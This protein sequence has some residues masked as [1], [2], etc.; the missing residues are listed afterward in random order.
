MRLLSCVSITRD[1]LSPLW[2]LSFPLFIFCGRVAER[3]SFWC[4]YVQ[5]DFKTAFQTYLLNVSS[6][7][8]A[9]RISAINSIL[10]AVS[11]VY[12]YDSVQING[13]SKNVDLESGQMPVLGTV[14][15]TEG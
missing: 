13:A 10:G 4:G 14:K 2:R 5:N 11:G 15:I 7:D 3:T 9:V 8:S 1:C 6:N 12:D